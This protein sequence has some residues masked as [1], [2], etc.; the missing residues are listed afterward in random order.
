MRPFAL[1][2]TAGD[3]AF[4]AGHHRRALPKARRVQI[5]LRSRCTAMLAGLRTL[6]RTEQGPDRYVP[7]A[8]GSRTAEFHTSAE[9]RLLTRE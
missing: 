2:I 9:T 3:F 8:T 6:I 1:E 4:A 5:S 7:F